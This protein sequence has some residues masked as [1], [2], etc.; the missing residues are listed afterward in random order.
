VILEFAHAL[1]GCA[2]LE[3]VRETFGAEIAR[4]G[5][6]ASACRALMPSE[7][8]SEWH[9]Y[10]REC[11]K[12]WAKLA[13]SKSYSRKSAV[14]AEARGRNTPFTWNDVKKG[15]TFTHAEQEV[16]EASAAQGWINGFVVPIHGPAYFAC[17]GMDSPEH[18]LDLGLDQRL[19][20]HI[21]A[22]MT[23]E[24]CRALSAPSM[25]DPATLLT[26]RELDCLRWVASGKTD[27]EIGV[28]L[29]ISAATARFHIDRAREKLGARSRSQAVA[30]LALSGL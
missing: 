16:W 5:Y 8:G 26:T 24:R 6:T 15:K 3:R 29:G 12:D 10:F 21:V 11:P 28:I 1:A 25:V 27:W 7:K 22:L 13:D 23:H 20:L 18:D 9:F 19:H 4:E 30:R 2:T 17:I 14:L